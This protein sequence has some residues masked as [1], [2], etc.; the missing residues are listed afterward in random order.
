MVNDGPLNLIAS[1]LRA[2]GELR[3]ATDH[4]VYLDWMLMVMARHADDFEWLVDRAADWR[5]TPA[6][7]PKPAMPQRRGAKA[8][9]RTSS[10]IAAPGRAS[11][12]VRRSFAVFEQIN[13]AVRPLLDLADARAHRPMVGLARL[14]AVES[15]GP[16]LR[17]TTPRKL[18]RPSNP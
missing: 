1:K 4:P 9:S 16:A 8:A 11:A 12:A 7:G 13:F 17:R 2:G 14:V 15:L 18:R 3:I 5:A 10:A 6:A